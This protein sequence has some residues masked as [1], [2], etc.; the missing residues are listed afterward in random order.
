[1]WVGKAL[2]SFLSWSILWKQ[3]LCGERRYCL[4]QFQE[5]SVEKELVLQAMPCFLGLGAGWV[6]QE[7][8]TRLLATPDSCL[9]KATQSLS[10]GLT[11]GAGTHQVSFILTFKLCFWH[12]YK[13]CYK[14]VAVQATFIC[15]AE[16]RTFQKAKETVKSRQGKKQ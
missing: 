7:V 14:F 12:I 15:C 13:S 8:V 16:Q 5:N 1:M 9:G 4:C 10:C 11:S 3:R 6:W 2:L